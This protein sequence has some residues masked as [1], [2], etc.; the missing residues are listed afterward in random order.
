MYYDRTV[1]DS[2]IVEL[3]P[4]GAFSFLADIS[5]RHHW[6]DLQLRSYPGK[7]ACWATL[8]FGL[9]KIIDVHER[10]GSFRLKGGKHAPEAFSPDWTE[11]RVAGD[12]R[13]P[14]TQEAVVA[15][16]RAA[17]GA[18]DDRFSHEGAIQAML[19]TRAAD[20]FSVVDREAVVGFSNTAER[21]AVY[22]ALQQPLHDAISPDPTRKWWKPKKFGGELDVLAVD[23]AGRL[24]TIEVKPGSATDGVT[25]SPLQA[26]FYARL[27]SAWADERG[28]AAVDDIKSMLDQRVDLGLT[29]A[30]QRSLRSPLEVV[31]VVAIGG[32]AS[33][34]ALERMRAVQQALVASGAGRDDLEIWQVEE[35]VRYSHIPWSEG[36]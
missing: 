28:P 16:V 22:S 3:K 7:P 24:L 17:M 12:W 1:S 27:F 29:S 9:T 10:N 35:I 13:L 15:Y 6:A 31:P 32:G 33:P 36:A 30:R 23:D 18:V 21:D 14:S 8:Y 26:T 34:A 5:R 11:K 4:D 2:L 25:W 19:C 20:L